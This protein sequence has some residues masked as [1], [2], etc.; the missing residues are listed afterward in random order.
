MI[1]FAEGKEQYK[2]KNLSGTMSFDTEVFYIFLQE[3]N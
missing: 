2:S 1:C 3:S